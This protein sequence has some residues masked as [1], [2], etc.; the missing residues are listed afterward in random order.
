MA[1]SRTGW[2]PSTWSSTCTLSGPRRGTASPPARL[3][4]SEG[5]VGAAAQPG[6]VA[7]AADPPLAGSLCAAGLRVAGALVAAGL[8]VAAGP[9]SAAGQTRDAESPSGL[10][11]APTAAELADRIVGPDG[12]DLPEGS[13]NAA[14]GAMVFA[15]RGCSNC[16]G[17]TGEEGPS[18]S[19]VG[20][21][22]TTRT[23]YWPI[24][25]WPFAPGI[26]DY[27]RRVMP[28]DRPGI[29]TDDE[30]YAVTAY[31][32]YRNDLISEEAVMDAETLPQVR[33][34]RRDDYVMPGTWTPETR[35]GFRIESD[36]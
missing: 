14:E 12:A 27:I 10:G 21:D 33:M 8:L 6:G 15:R 1:R 13:G 16:H 5:S 29:L 3:G 25:H 18:I 11:R 35:R 34:P 9:L 26:W 7:A 31:L 20:G 4:L 23:N 2:S 22:V 19:L 36:R 17:P 32:L 28:Y 30:T 24:R